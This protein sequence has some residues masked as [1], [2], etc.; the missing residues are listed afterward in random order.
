MTENKYHFGLLYI[1]KTDY[2]YIIVCTNYRIPTMLY[3]QLHY[4]DY[5]LIQYRIYE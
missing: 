5:A 1:H 2:S 3:M 4:K